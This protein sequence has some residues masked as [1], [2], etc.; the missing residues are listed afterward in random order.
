MSNFTKVVRLGTTAEY[1]A[2]CSI[3]CK[4]SF[5]DGNLSITGVEG[6]R[7]DG[8]AKGSCG[9]IVMSLN[10]AN[11]TPAPGWTTELIAQFLDTWNKWHL[12]NMQA[13]SPAQVAHLVTL[14]WPGYPVSHYDWAK[15]QL[16]AA[17]LQPDPTYSHNGKPYNY[18]SAW[19]RKEVPDAVIAFLQALPDTDVQPAWV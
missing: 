11:I 6:P 10:A 9:Q 12:N 2:P 14:T 4:I 1:G 5:T 16:E 18:G 3:F 7:K 15:A 13:G 8:N 19:L 17:G